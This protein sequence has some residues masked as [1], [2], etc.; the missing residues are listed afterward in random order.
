M[1]STGGLDV[2]LGPRSLRGYERDLL[3]RD[4]TAEATVGVLLIQ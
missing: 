1:R 2:R 3:P 4:L